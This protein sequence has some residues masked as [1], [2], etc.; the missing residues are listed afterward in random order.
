VKIVLDAMGGDKGLGTVVDGGLLAA[1]ELGVEIVFVG[2]QAEIESELRNRDA[3]GARVSVVHAGEVIEM[4]DEP[5][6]AVHAKRDSSMVVGMQMVKRGDASAFVSAGNSGGVLAAAQLHLARV[7]GVRRAAL[8]TVYPT[9]HGRCFVLD[10]GATT[11]CKPEY[12]Y[13]FGIMGSAYA[14]SVLQVDRPRV[15]ILSTGEEEG[16]GSVLVKEAAALL[17]AG[18]LNFIGNVEGKDI[19][20]HQADVVVVD[21]FTG[22]VFIK[23]SEGVA[24]LLLKTLERE[25]KRRPHAM[26]G[27]L[28]ARSALRATRSSLDYSDYGGAALLGV[29]GV[30]IVAHGRSNAKAIKSAVRVAQN[31]VDADIIRTIAEGVV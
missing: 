14:R 20:D 9:L 4:D 6:A 7:A 15:G 16:K 26:L 12:L 8:G 24:T 27:A 22:N 2:R 31:A 5:G 28:L 1:R 21:G 13:Q 18:S 23:T 17:R 19:P 10:V 29:N 25:I 30:A 11:D 3:S